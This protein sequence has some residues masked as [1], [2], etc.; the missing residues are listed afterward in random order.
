MSLGSLYS[1]YRTIQHVDKLPLD[2]YKRAEFVLDSRVRVQQSEQGLGAGGNEDDRRER[3]TTPFWSLRNLS[4]FCFPS[5]NNTLPF[6]FDSLLC[7][8]R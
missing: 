1:L 5:T 4:V 7:A 3:A 6:A 2:V 8:P